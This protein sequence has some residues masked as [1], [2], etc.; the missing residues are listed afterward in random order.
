VYPRYV[1]AAEADKNVRVEEWQRHQAFFV[2]T[3]SVNFPDGG[4]L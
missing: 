3:E 4:G 1:Y 2:M